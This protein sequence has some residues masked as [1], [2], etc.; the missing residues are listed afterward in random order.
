M[1]ASITVRVEWCMGHR[2]PN[3]EGL[4]RNLH[5][6]QYVLEATIE[7]VIKN[8][9]SDR[10]A[11]DEGMVV[12]FSDLKNALRSLAA[13]LDH[14][15]LISDRDP[16]RLSLEDMPGVVLVSFVPTAENIGQMFLA[17]LPAEVTRVKVWETPT[18]F[19]EVW[20]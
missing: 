4:C 15:F 13:D 6:H 14:T 20:R 3:H 12:D 18:S 17:G 10:G 19:A 5:G 11:P 16:F 8:S 9:D 7:G 1:N 2:L